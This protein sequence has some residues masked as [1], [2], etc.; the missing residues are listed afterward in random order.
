M[1]AEKMPITSTDSVTIS[2]LDWMKKLAI[3]ATITIIG[4][5]HQPLDP[6][7]SGRA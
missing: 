5:D 3:I 2:A 7:S 4:A 1:K 6:S